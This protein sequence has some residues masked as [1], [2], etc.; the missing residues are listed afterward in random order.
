MKVPDARTMLIT[1]ARLVEIV[2]SCT[3]L[4]LIINK[5]VVLELGPI[6]REVV[7]SI[8]IKLK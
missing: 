4:K 2:I 8:N 7:L 5:G 1:R 3:R 6:S